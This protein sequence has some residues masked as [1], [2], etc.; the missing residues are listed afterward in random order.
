MAEVA[1]DIGNCSK[2]DEK[3]KESSK[4][5]RFG[6]EAIPAGKVKAPLIGCEHVIANIE[7][8]VEDAKLISKYEMWVLKPVRAWINPK[9]K[10]GNGG[11]MFHHRGDG[12]FV[13][14][15]EF[16]WISR[17]GWSNGRS[18]EV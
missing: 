7:C 8:V 11:K 5:E 12:T 10:P 14:N 13:V 1:V 3:L 15:G 2:D 18:S 6:L 16:F 9:K 4:W 17:T